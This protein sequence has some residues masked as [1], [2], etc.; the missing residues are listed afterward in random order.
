MIN[1][2]IRSYSEK[3]VREFR[4]VVA[5]EY[6]EYVQ[7]PET[8]NLIHIPSG[9]NVTTG[10]KLDYLFRAEPAMTLQCRSR[11]YGDARGFSGLPS[12]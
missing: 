7:P 3:A 11:R 4:L 10:T 1:A 6:E 8:S 12:V 2:V 9:F 5:A